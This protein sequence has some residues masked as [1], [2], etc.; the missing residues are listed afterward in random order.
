MAMIR[1]AFLWALM[2]ATHGNVAAAPVSVYVSPR[3]NDQWS[4][5]L[6]QTNA[7]ETDGPL[8]TIQGA[9]DAIRKLKSPGPLDGPVRVIIADGQYTLASPLILEPQDSGRSQSP[10]SYEAAAGA[11]PVFSGGRR[12]TGFA[13]NSDGTWVA[14]LPDVKEGKWCFEQLWVDGRRAIRARSP[15]SF[16]Y[17][18]LKKAEPTID[19]STGKEVA[20]ANRA[21]VARKADIRPLTG[22]SKEQLADVHLI[23]YFSWATSRVPLAGV[24]GETGL[25]TLAGNTVWPIG[26]WDPAQRYHLENLKAALDA[27]GEWFL[28]R[29][30]GRLFYRPLP[31]EDPEKA[32]VV[33]PMIDQFVHFKGDAARGQ[34]VEHVALKGLSFQHGQYLTPKTGFHDP[35]AA[36][37]ISAALVADGARNI[38]IENCEIAHIGTYAVWFRNGCRDSRLIQTYMHDLGAGGVRIGE[39]HWNGAPD[40]AGLTSHIAA[41]NNIIRS[42]GH[43]FPEAVGVYIGHSPDNMVTHNEIADL[44][45]TGVSVGWVWGYGQSLAVRNK[46]EFNHI[47]HI[48]WGVLSDMGGVYSLGISPGTTISNNVVHDIWAYSYGGWGL[49]TDEG[50]TGIAMENNL[51]YNTKT[52]SFHQHYGKE[53]TIRNN[54]L[55]NSREWQIQRSRSEPHLSF[56]FENNIVY[57]TTGPLLG[58]T[59][60]DTEHYRLDRNIYWNAAGK[61]VTFANGMTLEQWRAKGQ[62]VNSIIADPMFVDP[63]K[64]DYRLKE[65]SPA[66]KAGFKPFDYGKAGVYGDQA[67]IR[68]ANSATFPELQIAPPAPPPEPLTFKDGFEQTAVGAAPRQAT[69]YVERRGDG[70]AVV[71]GDAAS[72]KRCLKITDAPTL[73]AVF[74]PHFYFVPG[75]RGGTSRF[76]FDIRISPETNMYVE[77]RDDSPRYNVGPTL[78][79]GGGKV[80]T[81]GKYLM[82]MPVNQWV[83]IDMSATIGSATWDLAITPTG[84]PTASFKALPG[85]PDFKRLEWLG[86]SSMNNDKAEFFLDNLELENSLAER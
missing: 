66:M 54:I 83:H 27:P 26:Q 13:V 68:L 73:Q 40:G 76:S 5:R 25:V 72:G 61:P 19:P 64:H 46:I 74:N 65:G 15:N 37:H 78:S 77:W 8:S 10:I 35:Q 55:V 60:A 16:Y 12:I 14:Q 53:N 44:R 67:W 21:F 39:T 49:Y 6:A 56:T 57:W 22:L 36:S 3:G 48:G 79:I 30:E 20:M 7:D 62:D 42:A 82:D 47:H 58:S 18:M 70:V 24:D 45:Y 11:K 41:D 29:I 4:G 80:H 38:A 23:A 50:S 84:I 69:V 1:I 75:H 86:F 51:V 52:G 2:L 31:G 32:V 17:H 28:D 34:F 71:E 85:S 33:A 81:R 9:R 59:W 63:A 43:L